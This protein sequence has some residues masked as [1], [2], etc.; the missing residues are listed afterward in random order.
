MMRPGRA[1]LSAARDVVPSVRLA[2][3]VND[4]IVTSHVRALLV[5][6]DGRGSRGREP[7]RPGVGA[8]SH[9]SEPS[10]CTLARRRSP[11]LDGC[12]AGCRITVF[13]PERQPAGGREALAR[14]RVE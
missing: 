1:L 9:R 8:G 3:I 5:T 11:W 6:D 10:G 13:S 14:P 4:P 7:D 12:S 2:Y